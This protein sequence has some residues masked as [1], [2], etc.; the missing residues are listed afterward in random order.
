LNPG[1]KTG[2]YLN[3]VLAKMEANRLG[4]K[5][6]LMANPYGQL[7][8]CTTSNLFFVK[9]DR[10]LTPSLD[11]GILPGITR[12][13]VIQLARENGILVEEGEWPPEAL[14]NADEIFLTGTLKRVMPITRYNDRKV[15]TG[16]PGPITRKIMR[17]YETFLDQSN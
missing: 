11:C 3:N 12:N 17:L 7:T 9:E 6:A 13:V 8:E 15:G 14:D 4:A 5:E 1:I 16:K 10:I 2:N